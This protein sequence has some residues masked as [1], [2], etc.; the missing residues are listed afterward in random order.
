M[1][2][3]GNGQPAASVCPGQLYAVQVGD[4]WYAR[5]SS[6]HHLTMARSF[7]AL[8]STMRAL[9]FVS[10]CVKEV[11]VIK[12]L[13]YLA[14]DYHGRPTH[15]HFDNHSRILSGWRPSLVSSRLHQNVFKKLLCFQNKLQQ[16]ASYDN[17]TQLRSLAVAMSTSAGSFATCEHGSKDTTHQ[18][19]FC[20][21]AN[22]VASTWPTHRPSI[23]R[24]CAYQHAETCR[25]T[26]VSRGAL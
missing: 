16:H 20:T 4:A 11:L 1:F 26:S 18:V 22:S 7:V 6:W 15:R 14:V 5:A 24:C 2:L 10:C 25:R 19:C 3:D 21:A 9:L 12:I 23:C 8:M 17:A 13:N